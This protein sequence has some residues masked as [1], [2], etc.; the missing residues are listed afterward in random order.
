MGL[1]FSKSAYLC[2]WECEIDQIQYHFETMRHHGC[3]HGIYGFNENDAAKIDMLLDT[4]IDIK[5]G[6]TARLQTLVSGQYMLT[7]F[8]LI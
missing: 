6:L 1:E 2:G 5:N 4:I 3:Q 7:I 8:L